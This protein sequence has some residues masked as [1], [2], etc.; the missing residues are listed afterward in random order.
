MAESVSL[1]LTFVFFK[2][3]HHVAQREQRKARAAAKAAGSTPLIR[4]S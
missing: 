2:H 4:A 1:F 3:A